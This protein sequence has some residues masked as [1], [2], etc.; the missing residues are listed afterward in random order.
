MT[1]SRQ[2]IMLIGVTFLLISSAMFWISVENTRSYL[3]LQLATQTQNAADSLGLSLVPHMQHKDI[4]AMDTMINAAFDSGYYTSLTLTNMAGDTLIERENTSQI[5]GVPQWFIDTLKLETP[6]AESII[7]TGWRQAGHLRLQANAGFAYQKLWQTS[8]DM[9]WCS[10]IIFTVSLL[11]VWLVLKAILRPLG[12]VE[13]QAIAIS[14]REF[15]V[16]KNIPHTRELKRVVLAM[17]QMSKKIGGFIQELTERAE[18]MRQD[19]HDDALTGLINRRGFEARLDHVL[20]DKEQG[21]SGC[22][23]LI[24]LHEFGAYNQQLGHMAGDDLLRDVGALL[25]TASEPYASATA[26]RITGTDFAVILPLVQADVAAEFGAALAH[27]LHALSSTLSVQNIAHIGIACF[28][29]ATHI[30]AVMADADAGLSLAEQQGENTYAVQSSKSEARGNMAWKDLITQAIEHQKVRFLV[31]PVVNMV[32]DPLYSEMLMRIQDE[33]GD[34]VSPGL[35]AA[36]AERLDLCATVDRFVLEQA[37]GLLKHDTTRSLGVNI[38]AGS[39]QDK[40]FLSWLKGFFEQH[41]DVVRHM[42]VEISEHGVLQDIQATQSLIDLV[43]A[44]EANVVVE[45]FGT[46]MSSFQSL[47]QLKCD[48]IKL[49]GSYVRNIAEHSDNRFFLQTVVDIAR[50]LDMQV[51][52]EHVEN[53]ADFVC[54]KAL[55]VDAVQGYF[56]GPPHPLS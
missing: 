44:F 22:L 39:I 24:R 20:R 51:I 11:A 41:R 18:Q 7:T 46:R 34:D 29:D 3:V 32:R 30:G 36:M 28:H 53:D 19:A 47:Q 17:N 2:L 21:G 27:A 37:V 40:L 15:S 42:Y 38:S 33:T 35:F 9:L 8:V 4:A 31:Q 12:E 10:L 16:L 55:G 23:A 56:V 48:A 13:R 52:A 45:H 26:A 43:H 14:Q 54:L 5:S 1:L 25:R 50:G 6:Q 49:D